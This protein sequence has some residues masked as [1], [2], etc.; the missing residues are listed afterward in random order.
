M[1]YCSACWRREL[2]PTTEQR[3]RLALRF[4]P[5]DFQQLSGTSK[6]CTLVHYIRRFHEAFRLGIRTTLVPST[7]FSSFLAT[8]AL[9]LMSV[10][11]YTSRETPMP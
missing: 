6:N 11:V 4:R 2:G 3:S 1:T 9:C 8:A 5:R 10:C 7:E